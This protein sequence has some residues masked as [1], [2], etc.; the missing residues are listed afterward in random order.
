MTSV[1]RSGKSVAE[2]VITSLSASGWTVTGLDVHVLYTTQLRCSA[3]FL[4]VSVQVI[5]ERLTLLFDSRTDGEDEACPRIW[6]ATS[7]VLPGEVIAA[8]ARADE[9]PEASDDDVGA[10]L[11]AAG[12][13]AAAV[14][15]WVSPDGQRCVSYLADG[16]ASSDDAWLCWLVLRRDI[17]A[18]ARATDG[19]PAAVVCAFALTDAAS[20]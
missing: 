8:V 16:A 20:G 15:G 4:M 17:N 5:G 3:V 12:W 1:S 11:I 19:T 6:H 10:R 18:E 2:Q 13:R 14:H 7:T 9:A